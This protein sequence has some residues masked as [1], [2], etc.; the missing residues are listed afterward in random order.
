MTDD[1]PRDILTRYRRIAV[2]G[3][4]G[5]PGKPAHD[6]PLLMRERGYDVLPVNPRLTEWEGAPSF[7]SLA[8]APQPEVVNVFR[9]AAEAPAI[10]QA[11]ADAGAKV[12]WLQLGISSADARAIAADAG[13]A[14]VE[15]RCI[16]VEWRR[17]DG[18]GVPV[19]GGHQ[20]AQ[21]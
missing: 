6:V 17:L 12:L 1:L 16:N 2:V 11:A 13:L 15:D 21:G 20:P 8:D 19:P 4:S 14:Y 5:T 10:A 3:A 9:P 7:P 18:A